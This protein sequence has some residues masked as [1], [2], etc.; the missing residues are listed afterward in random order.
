VDP[1]VGDRIEALDAAQEGGAVVAA[2]GV[3]LAVEGGHAQ[4]TPLRQHRHRLYPAASRR[5]VHLTNRNRK[6]LDEFKNIKQ[7]IQGRNRMS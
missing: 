7:S 1:L 3:D 4:P 2:T 6:S 5:V